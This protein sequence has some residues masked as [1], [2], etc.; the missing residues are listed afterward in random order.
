MPSLEQTSY[1]IEPP[2]VWIELRSARRA[3]A[4]P[5][6]FLDRDGVVIEEKN[7]LGDPAGVALIPGAAELI[8]DANGRG[9]P[10]ALITNQSGIARGYYGWDAFA[11]VEDEM[12]R[13]LAARGARIDAVAACPLHAEHTPGFDAEMARW[14]KPG[15]K[16]ITEL[17]RR[18]NVALARSWLVGDK[19]VDVRAARDAGLAGAIHVLTG[20]G[21]TFRDEAMAE[22][23]DGFRVLAADTPRDCRVILAGLS[24]EAS[25]R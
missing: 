20:H 15:P 12:M 1:P 14:V 2:G 8:T 5:G 18:L 19:A 13:Q 24:A 22:A 6:L 16:M 23:T 17:A 10:V 9:V 4:V 11:A 7:Y 3:C 25:K 21:K